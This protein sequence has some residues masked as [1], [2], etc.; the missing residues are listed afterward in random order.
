MK[1]GQM[2]WSQVLAAHPLPAVGVLL[3]PLLQ[4]LR[5]LQ[6]EDVALAGAPGAVAAHRTALAPEHPHPERTSLRETKQQTAFVHSSVNQS[7]LPSVLLVFLFLLLDW[8]TR[9]CQAGD[10]SHAYSRAMDT[11][12]KQKQK[13]NVC[14]VDWPRSLKNG[15]TAL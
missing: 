13:K 1:M 14:V 2:R 11:M 6:R 9:A 12:T 3:R 4:L 5:H 7:V 15:E 8:V 10:T